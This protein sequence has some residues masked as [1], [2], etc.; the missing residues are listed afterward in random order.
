MGR[1]N[2]SHTKPQGHKTLSVS[3]RVGERA[4]EPTQTHAHTRTEPRKPLRVGEL[5][6]PWVEQR[7]SR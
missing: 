2:H 5:Y 4:S 6:T 7:S 1:K 3:K